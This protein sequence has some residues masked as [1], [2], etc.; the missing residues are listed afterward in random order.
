MI[1]VI[2]VITAKPGKRE[3]ILVPK[4]ALVTISG[5]SGVY[6][7]GADDQALFQM[8]QAG[9]EQGDRVEVLT[10]LK[11]GDRVVADQRSGRIDGRKIIMAEK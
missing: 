10:G 11:Q 8:V 6:V 3:A 7:V 1:H 9:E 2:A 4:E 5:V